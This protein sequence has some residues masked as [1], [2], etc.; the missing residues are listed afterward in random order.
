MLTSG[1]KFK[2]IRKILDIKTQ[3]EL[4]KKT[5]IKLSSIRDIEANKKNISSDIAIILEEKL[6]VNFKWLLTGEGEMMLPKGLQ[7]IHKN[8]QFKS[9]PV[10]LFIEISKILSD[11]KLVSLMQKAHTKENNPLK[12]MLNYCTNM[13]ELYPFIEAKIIPLI[14]KICHEYDE[15]VTKEEVAKKLTFSQII[16]IPAL[17]LEFDLK[18]LKNIEIFKE[19]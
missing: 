2:L 11:E 3:P 5:G 9:M 4:A 6:N 10:N 13:Q 1:E 17:Q 16:M 12:S 7:L 15:E 18:A 19:K 14:I 8:Y